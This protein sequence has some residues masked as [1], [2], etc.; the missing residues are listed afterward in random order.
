MSY[1]YCCLANG[2]CDS[3]TKHDNPYPQYS[4]E[5]AAWE[6]GRQNGINAASWPAINESN[7]ERIL[8]GG[9]PY[10]F[11]EPNLTGERA[12]DYSEADLLSDTGYVPHDGEILRD[13]L[14]EIYE[15]SAADAFWGEIDRRCR[16]YL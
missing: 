4:P 5:H 15:S 10:E 9:D 13:E 2:K 11:A 3:T 7:A 12:G 1:W 6:V 14:C 16:L 8:Q